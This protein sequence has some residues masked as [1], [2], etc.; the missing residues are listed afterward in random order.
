MSAKNTVIR[1]AIAGA[2]HFGDPIIREP[3]EIQVGF[4]LQQI[5]QV[6]QQ[7]ERFGV[8]GVFRAEWTDKNLAFDASDHEATTLSY[9][10]R[11]LVSF[12][13]EN[14]IDWPDFR[15]VNQQTKA[16]QNR[17]LTIDSN[18]HVFYEER[19][20]ATLQAPEFDFRRFPFDHQDFWVRIETQAP[21]TFA[22]LVLHEN[23]DFNR[24]GEKLGEEEWEIIEA[25]PVITDVKGHYR[26]SLDI[27]AKRHTTYYI[28]RILFPI[29]LIVLIGWG[30]FLIFD[31]NAQI[32]AASGNLLIFIA[33]NFTVGDSLPR[34]GYLTFL[35]SIMLAGFVASIASLLLALYLKR[36]EGDA[37]ADY[38]K[39]LERR[40]LLTLPPAF[41]AAVAVSVVYFFIIL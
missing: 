25:V 8:V 22:T 17:V 11:Q 37:S 4:E 12:L 31:H 27:R 1:D 38:A 29:G 24:I 21:D 3:K 18:G 15:I 40:A 33:F 28:F 14:R 26:F 7:N 20:T 35:D 39:V 41:I 34:L 2:Q 16:T 6:D 32:A 36:T 5:T 13:E 10:D 23:P 19:F 30:I 9:A